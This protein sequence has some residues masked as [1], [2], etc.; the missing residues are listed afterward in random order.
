MKKLSFILT[1]VLIEFSVFAQN[2]NIILNNYISVK[3]ALVSSNGKVA[4]ETINALYNTVK[5]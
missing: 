5:N 4:S 3:N 1:V 2:T